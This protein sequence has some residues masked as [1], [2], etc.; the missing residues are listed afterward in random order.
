MK[1][2]KKFNSHAHKS[3]YRTV[4]KM[5]PA[6]LT[7]LIATSLGFISL[8]T[9][10]VP[11]IQDFGKMLTIGMIISFIV[12]VFILIP[13]LYTRD[14]FFSNEAS[15]KRSKKT[16]KSSRFEN[17]LDGITKKVVALRW[18]IILIATITAGFGIWVDLDA[19]AETDVETFMPQDTQVLKDIQKLR[20]IV[21]TTDQVSI[22][23]EGKDILSPSSLNWVDTTTNEIGKEFSQVVVKSNSITEVFKKLN[24]GEIPTGSGV[25]E[26]MEDIPD[27]QQKLLINESSTKGVITVGIEHLEAEPLKKFID[28]LNQYLDD[29]QPD[30]METMVTGK[31]VL[32]VEM[33]SGLTTG[34]YKM[35]LLGMALVFLGLLAVYRHPI[36]ALIPLLPITLIIGW[37]G[38]VMFFAEISYT[39]LT[40][41]LGALIIGIGT[42]FTILIMERFYEEREN[43]SSSIDAIRIANQKTGKSIFASAITTIG[44]FSALLVSDFVI[45]SNFGMMTLINIS[46]ALFSTIV[47]MPAVLI[48]LDRFVKTKPRRE[49]DIVVN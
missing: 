41:T 27:Q 40:A 7:A 34:R 1:Q 49:K 36:K 2:N 32:D 25:K 21:G 20:G 18:W 3:L 11:M 10:P 45:L 43:G 37:S 31:S 28:D 16:G 47:V 29:N 12:G 30:N 35:T 46:L 33:V 26:I 8:Y 22:V 13:L 17:F 6:V 5:V 23:Y 39:P 9:S 19:K 4:T 15:I 44:G 42:E 24:N 38:A 14:Y 48:I